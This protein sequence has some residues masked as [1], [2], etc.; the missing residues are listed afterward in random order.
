MR[1]TQRVVVVTGASRGIGAAVAQDLSQHG[2]WVWM[3]ARDSDSLQRVAS[4]IRDQGGRA[5]FVPF[6]ITDIE[7]APKVF[8]RISK[9]SGR[10]DGL[11]NNAGTTR[12]GSLTGISPEDYDDVMSVNVR[13]LLFLPKLPYLL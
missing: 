9:E 2:Y 13:S 3:V 8:E 10:L 5:D 6:D 7:N 11:V 4:S 1:Q 12:R